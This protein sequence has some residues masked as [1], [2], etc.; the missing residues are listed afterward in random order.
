MKFLSAGKVPTEITKFS[1]QGKDVKI[2]G[3]FFMIMH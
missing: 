3:L 2:T 1:F